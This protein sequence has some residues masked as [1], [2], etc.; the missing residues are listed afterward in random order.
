MLER[1]QKSLT[2]E[3][4]SHQVF[5]ILS[6]AACAEHS[7]SMTPRFKKRRTYLWMGSLRDQRFQLYHLGPNPRNDQHNEDC[8]NATGN[9]CNNRTK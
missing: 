9:H 4:P 8:A 3:T 1:L 7:R 5:L 2:T 6:V